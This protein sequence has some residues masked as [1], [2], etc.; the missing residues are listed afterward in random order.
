MPLHQSVEPH[1]T[2]ILTMP[3]LP[4]MVL[5][6]DLGVAWEAPNGLLSI[7]LL[8][9]ATL[10]STLARERHRATRTRCMVRRVKLTL[11]VRQR[12]VS[13]SPWMA[14]VNTTQMILPRAGRITPAMP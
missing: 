2:L 1:T 11:T 5:R 6:Q 13:D 9:R 4:K 12:T 10:L 7:M 14:I 8:R 3:V